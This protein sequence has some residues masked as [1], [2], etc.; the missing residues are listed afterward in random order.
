MG[1]RAGARVNDAILIILAMKRPEYFR[2]CL[3]AWG[4]ARGSQDLH[5]VTVRTGRTNPALEGELAAIAGHAAAKYGWP[6]TVVPDDPEDAGHAGPDRA[7][8]MQI[9]A[10]FADPGCG[11][12]IECDEDIVVSDDVLEYMAF[13]RSLGTDCACAHNDLGQGWSP[14][15]DDSAAD[16]RVVRIRG[17]FTSWCFGFTR[18]AW[19]RTWLPEWDWDRTSGDHPM[20]HGWEW[21]MHRQAVRD[22]LRIAIPDASR[23]QDIGQFAGTFSDPAGFWATQAAS[24]R[25]HREPVAYVATDETSAQ[26]AVV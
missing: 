13:A 25:P 10:S 3:E 19:E 15:R 12:V 21:Q 5:G 23:C 8:G 11:F 9:Q 1:G 22:N 7:L 24:Y 16:Q 2:R 17:E 18:E 4:N 20:Q 6:L 26:H 14:R